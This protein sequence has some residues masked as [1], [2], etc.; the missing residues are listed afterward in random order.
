[1]RNSQ[2]VL[3]TPFLRGSFLR[4]AIYELSR[5][6]QGVFGDDVQTRSQRLE[7]TRLR[8][9]T[10]VELLV[11]IA[12]ISMLVSLL[13]PAVNAAR[14]AARRSSCQNNLVQLGLALQMYEMA[15]E[16][17]PPGV[18]NPSGPIQNIESGQHVSWIVFSL[19]Y[20]EEAA[21]YN[22]IN[23][24]AGAY[25]PANAK[26]RRYAIAAIVCPSSSTDANVSADEYPGVSY[27]GCHHDVEAPIDADN[28]GLLFL[29]SAVT[30][31]D[32]SDGTG[33][34]ILMG[35]KISNEG[36][37][38][39]WISGTRQTLR[40][41]GT[42]PR[43]VRPDYTRQ[44]SPPGSNPAVSEN[45]LYV[46]GFGSNHSGDSSN[47]AFADGAVRTIFSGIDAVVWQHLGHRSDGELVDPRS[48]R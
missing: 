32:I 47:F 15:H 43:A 30:F 4:S 46:G 10:L 38:E 8:G 6:A 26:V 23:I 20:V 27:A 25:D 35:D 17:L 13:L 7:G 24:A 14:E 44:E 16:H 9:F 1:M 5:R 37:P 48:I 33:K 41:T 31:R 40:N 34:T 11:V 29:N 39:G 3:M 21:A 19:P 12:I 2:R 45:P 36:D 42:L 18:V 22:L 28:H